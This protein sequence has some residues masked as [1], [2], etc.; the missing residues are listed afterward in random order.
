GRNTRRV[1]RPAPKTRTSGAARGSPPAAR[2]RPA[3]RT[4][5]RK[6][7][8]APESTGAGAHTATWRSGTGRTSGPPPPRTPPRHPAPSTEGPCSPEQLPEQ[9]FRFGAGAVEI[10]KGVD[11]SLDGHLPLLQAQA[12]HLQ[13]LSAHGQI[14]AGS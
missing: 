13:I 2:G 9:A 12:F 11:L 10:D 4:G 14:A 8:P 5:F 6:A 3:R 1:R 7:H